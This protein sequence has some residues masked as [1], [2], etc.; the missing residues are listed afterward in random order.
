MYVDQIYKGETPLKVEVD[1]GLHDISFQSERYLPYKSEIYIEGRYIEQIITAELSPAWAEIKISSNPLSADI[2][3]DNEILGQTPSEIELLQG[4][5]TIQI[6]K[7]GI[8]KKMQ[9]NIGHKNSN[10]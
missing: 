7:A 6:K 9:K 5:H 3:V 10:T 2:I 1:P 4:K 8:H